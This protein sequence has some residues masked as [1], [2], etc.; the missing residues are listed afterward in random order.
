MHQSRFAIVCVNQT[1]LLL[2]KYPPLFEH[3]LCFFNTPL[4]DLPVKD[5]KVCNI[6]WNKPLLQS[7]WVKAISVVFAVKILLLP[8]C[9]SSCCCTLV[10]VCV[11]VCVTWTSK[12][13]RNT[14]WT[15]AESGWDFQFTLT[16]DSRAC[17]VLRHCKCK[18]EMMDNSSLEHPWGLWFRRLL[19]KTVPG[20]NSAQWVASV[21][22]LWADT[23]ECGVSLCAR[24]C[25]SYHPP[26][27]TMT[28]RSLVLCLALRSLCSTET[29]AALWCPQGRASI[30]AGKSIENGFSARSASLR[31]SP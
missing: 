8:Y 3:A 4:N 28:T 7:L 18:V 10:G 5:D 13:I 1:W 24:S 19:E 25:F 27:I 11:C 17:V 29:I 22:Q 6:F 9:C 14:A 15:T 21:V 20:W 30:W 12:Q 26:C 31:Y 2:C 16:L 23:T